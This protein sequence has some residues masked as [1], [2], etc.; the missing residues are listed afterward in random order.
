MGNVTECMAGRLLVR[1]MR[2]D[3]DIMEYE[4]SI[5]VAML[6]TLFPGYLVIHCPTDPVP[7]GERSEFRVMEVTDR[8]CLGQSY[9]IYPI[10]P[11]YSEI[12]KAPQVPMDVMNLRVTLK[13]LATSTKVQ[14]TR[15]SKLKFLSLFACRASSQVQPGKLKSDREWMP[16]LH[17]NG[18]NPSVKNIQRKRPGFMSGDHPSVWKPDLDDIPEYPRGF[19]AL[20]QAYGE[21]EEK[22]W[23]CL[24]RLQPPNSDEDLG[25]KIGKMIATSMSSRFG[26]PDMNRTFSKSQTCNLHPGFQ[27][28]SPQDYKHSDVFPGSEREF[29]LT[30]PAFG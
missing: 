7:S 26:N 19:H 17:L 4:Y 8:L 27:E 2:P 14:R 13:S 5:Q 22:S 12:F 1:V 29:L 11:Q 25:P 3:G 28:L 24:D 20:P 23:P 9:I 16:L 6:M 30:E 21:V 18:S 15:R 10:P